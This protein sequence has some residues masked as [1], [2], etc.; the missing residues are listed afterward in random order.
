MKNNIGKIVF[1]LVFVFVVIAMFYLKQGNV[2]YLVMLAILII[3]P[4]VID[5]KKITSFSLD[6]Q[7]KKILITQA[8]K[9]AEEA[10]ENAK[11]VS[12]E[13]EITAT[14]F[15]KTVDSFLK[16]NMLALQR[17]GR[18]NMNTPW[19]D[20][21]QFVEEAKIL[22][23]LTK[24]DDDEI[25]Q[26]IQDSQCKVIELFEFDIQNYICEDKKN[27][28][29]QAISTG[30]YLNQDLGK[31]Y[32]NKKDVAINFQSL[33]ALK[34]SVEKAK[35]AQYIKSVDDLKEYYKNNFR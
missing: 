35:Q 20:A 29:E 13:V 21:A 8:L 4:W 9:E 5:I 15:S 10:S 22:Y 23:H 30:T 32:F 16:F 2:G 24:S 34:D 25:Q 31:L 6:I 7:N 26:L 33:Y 11:Q 1:S 17:E 19:Y 18:L 14:T 12:R 28:F 27:D 3:A